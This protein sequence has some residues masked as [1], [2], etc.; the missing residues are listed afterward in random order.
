MPSNALLASAE[1]PAGPVTC[2][3]TPSGKPAA[4]IVRSSSTASISSSSSPP[5]AIGTVTITPVPSSEG[6]GGDVAS[7]PGMS[8]SAKACR[9]LTISSCALRSSPSESRKTTIA[10]VTSPAG[11]SF[12]ASRTR[13]DSA[14]PGRKLDGSFCWA[15][16]NFPMKGP[17]ARIVSSHTASTT[18]FDRRPATSPATRLTGEVDRS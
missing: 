14:S 10:A 12:D 13:T 5:A 1:K 9:F 11:N 17:S 2:A 7:A 15:P 3:A 6:T 4:A 18:N 8:V 16:S